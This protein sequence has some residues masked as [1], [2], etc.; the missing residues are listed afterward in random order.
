MSRTDAELLQTG[1]ILL[2]ISEEVKTELASTGFSPR[3]DPPGAEPDLPDG[4]SRMNDTELKDLYDKFLQFYTYLSD[5]ATSSTVYLGVTKSRMDVVE[6]NLVMDAHTRKDELPNAEVRKAF[7]VAHAAM[8]ASQKDYL[9]FKQ[10]TDALERR[11]KKLSKSMDRLYRELMLRQ[12][13]TSGGG[14]YE[15][16]DVPKVPIRRAFKPIS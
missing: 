1:D 3:E 10:L 5:K 4:V 13:S 12:P 6:A 2:G 16:R 14:S 8:I 15:S 11:L 9:F 7:V